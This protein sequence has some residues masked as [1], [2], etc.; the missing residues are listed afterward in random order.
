MYEKALMLR[1]DS[2]TLQQIVDAIERE[3]NHKLRKGTISSWTRGISSPYRAGHLFVPKPSPDLAYVIG[4]EAGDGFL[5]LKQKTYQYRI[6]LR[7]VDREFVEAFS[8]AVSRVL[9]CPPHKLWK[10]NGNETEVEFGSYLLHKFLLQDLLKLR[11]FIEQDKKCVA[12]F[13]RGFLDSEGCVSSNGRLSASNSNLELLKYVQY[14]LRRYFGIESTGPR[15]GTKKGSTITRRGK[16]YK[17]NVDVYVIFV[18]ARS[19]RAFHKEIGLTIRRK[20]LRLEKA[21]KRA[22]LPK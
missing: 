2:Y 1:K 7:A 4:V 8:Q 20:K 22:R 13:I 9:G 21:S 15:L 10:G 16:S 18:R 19:L 5:N 3:Y 14:L 6:R 17:R 11:E 12:A